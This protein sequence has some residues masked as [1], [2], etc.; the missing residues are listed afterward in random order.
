MLLLGLTDGAGVP[1][2]PD[3]ELVA[4][5]MNDVV[6][7]ARHGH[8]QRQT[9]PLRELRFEQFSHKRA[10]D[11]GSGIHHEPLVPAR[12]RSSKVA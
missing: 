4:E 2:Q 8:S 10:V 5:P 1:R 12:T 9:G 3:R 6:R 11:S 7:S